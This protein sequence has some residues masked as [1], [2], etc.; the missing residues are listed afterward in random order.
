MVGFK[1]FADRTSVEFGPGVTAIVGPNGSG[2]SNIAD[3]IRWAL[4]ELQARALRGERLDDVIFAGTAA[5]RRAGWAQVEVVMENDGRLPVPAAEVSV[6]RRVDRAGESEVFLNGARCR[7]RD[8]Q[9]LLLGTGLGP[10]A[11][12]Y[13]GQ[14][15][16]E[17][18]LDGRPADRRALVE[19]AAGVTRYRARL[20]EAGRALERAGRLAERLRS[21]VE[22]SAARLEPLARQAERARARS[23]L[24]REVERLALGLLRAEWEDLSS[25][26]ARLDERLG[27]EREA[28]SG[29]RAEARELE[30]RLEAARAERGEREAAEAEVEARA[31]EAR[32]KAETARRRLRELQAAQAERRDAM[33]THEARAEAAR[34]DRERL[35][36]EAA[37]GREKAEALAAEAELARARRDEALAARRRAE[38]ALSAARRAARE[39]REELLSAE[40]AL[41]NAEAEERGLRERAEESR[42]RLEAALAEAEARLARSED[43]ARGAEEAWQRAARERRAAEAEWE[44]AQAARA[45]AERVAEEAAR[46]AEEAA[47]AEAEARSRAEVWRAVQAAGEGYAE[48]PRAVLRAKAEGRPEVAEVVGAVAELLRVEARYERA[49][50]V[51][52][53]PTAQYLVAR[54]AAGAGRAIAWLKAGKAGR[55]T[56]LP[57]D[58][59]R[60]EAP[61]PAFERLRREPGAVAWAAELVACE[62]EVRPAIEHLLGRVLVAA[63][64]RAAERLARASGLRLRVVT[65]DGEVVHPGGALTG[66]EAR[67]RGPSLVARARA[68]DE[69]GAAARDARQA[70]ARAR[71]AASR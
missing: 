29:H 57:L 6:L 41:A 42:A 35:L 71:E 33:R 4:G 66:G 50:E 60:R 12:A 68:A 32:E 52:L 47:R 58:G 8:V 69:A 18:V 9:E 15:Q 49:V 48:G 25:R 63:D 20:L 14:G 3:A 28:L 55:A 36:A 10:R 22:E 67:S 53:G 65:L 31:E 62:E 45:E 34:R 26:I 16:V 23:R 51:A 5:R 7:V 13:V 37:S 59:L 39:A 30:A 61:G 27:R 2:K 70:L 24:D 43:E 38:E 21:L 17:A 40:R 54:S 46:A 44:A 19:E 1:S 56:F 64:L 11:Y